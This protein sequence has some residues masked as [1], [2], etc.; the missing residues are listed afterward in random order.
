MGTGTSGPA[1]WSG[2][3]VEAEG[4]DDRRG[5]DGDEAEELSPLTMRR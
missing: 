1:A 2:V 3:G 5:E 4:A